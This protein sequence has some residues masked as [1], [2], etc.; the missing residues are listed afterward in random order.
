MTDKKKAFSKQS[1]VDINLIMNRFAQ[2]ETSTKPKDIPGFAQ[3][4][5]KREPSLEVGMT[6]LPID[7]RTMLENQIENNLSFLAQTSQL[8]VSDTNKKSKIKHEKNIVNDNSITEPI[9]KFQGIA[10]PYIPYDMYLRP[11]AYFNN[12]SGTGR[13]NSIKEYTCHIN[14]IN[15]NITKY[16]NPFHFLTKFNPIPGETD[17]YI[18]KKFENILYIKLKAAILPRRYYITK[19]LS[20]TTPPAEIVALY[21]ASFPP[22]DNDIINVA[23]TPTYAIIHAY[24]SAS[25]VLFDVTATIS[26]S[27]TFSFDDSLAHSFV[28][29]DPVQFTA[30]IFP[31]NVVA[32]TTYFINISG[33]TF[34]IHRT[35]TAA[36]AG[37]NKITLTST[38][39]DVKVAYANQVINYTEYE[40][41]ISIVITTAYE[42][43]KV[44]ASTPTYE[45]Y[46]F[47]LDNL[48]IENEK[49][50]IVGI[51]DINDVS[52]FST[53][54]NLIKA[55]TVLFP[56]TIY[57]NAI[58][59]D[60]SYSEK[61]YKYSELG[62]M[63][64]MEITLTNAI[65]KQLTTNTIAYDLNI[66]NVNTTSCT[67]TINSVTGNKERDYKCV[68]SYIRHPRYEKSQYDLMFK[69]G[70]IETDMNK[71]PFA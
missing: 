46:N 55:F 17:A 49:Y 5:D 54:Q 38:G 3:F 68:C 61:I 28:T 44:L 9:S 22:D 29:G 66:P 37:T 56:D 52:E 43:T 2:F 16:P 71:R 7:N 41:D 18:M 15:R 10:P 23:A 12:F 70:I 36:I 64:R 30:S 65:A 26:P 27:D 67:C 33:S 53:D 6:A 19:T 58:Y 48:S 31:N 63:S 59:S 25:D 35:Y 42:T 8:E 34:T 13:T 50:V 69:F 32:S 20:N 57:L 4:I 21:G 45:Q 24:Y 51:N 14:S 60:G 62:T 1:N 39:S 47:A 40:P 11:E